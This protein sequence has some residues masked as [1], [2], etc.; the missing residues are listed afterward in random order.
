MA[1][2]P[3]AGGRI[4]GCG[5][6]GAWGWGGWPAPGPG[7]GAAASKPPAAPSG[8]NSTTRKIVP[9]L[10]GSSDMRR[11]AASA[12]PAVDAGAPWLTH[13]SVSAKSGRPGSVSTWGDGPSLAITERPWALCPVTMRRIGLVHGGPR[14]G[15]YTAAQLGETVGRKSGNVTG[16]LLLEAAQA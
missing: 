4:A 5:G 10:G 15:L 11:L 12:P 2:S 9:L 16:R 8:G 7:R 13:R 3:V 1:E 6:A 14:P